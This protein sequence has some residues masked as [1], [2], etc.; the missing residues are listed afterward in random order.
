MN[1]NKNQARIV[2]V[3]LFFLCTLLGTADLMAEETIRIG[4]IYS[5]SGEAKNISD[6][7]L[8][9]TRFAVREINKNGGVLGRQLELIEVDNESSGIGS[10]NA[11]QFLVRQKVVAVVGPSWSSH[12]LSVAPVLQ[13]AAIPM[14]SPTATNPRVT[15]VGNYIFRICFID[16]FQGEMLAKFAYTDKGLKRAVLL[17]NSGHVYSTDLA[18]VIEKSYEQLGGKVLRSIDYVEDVSNYREIL[19]SLKDIKYDMIFIPGYARDAAHIIKTAEELGIETVFIGGDGWS[20][21]M[22]KYGGSSLN[23]NF[24]LT[25]WNK[26][27]PDKLSQDF[28]KKISTLFRPSQINAGMALAYDTIYLLADAITR[29]NSI[30][31]AAIRDALANTRK[32]TGVTGNVQFDKDR[33]PIKPAVVLEFMNGDA[34]V[35]KTIS[36]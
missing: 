28:V 15:L 5:L 25:H 7:H 21:L 19:Q 20:H 1:V 11:A 22:Y 14:L 26:S 34:I 2:T 16:S 10:R 18:D 23:G 4:A 6:E 27:V 33:N 30:E 32:F 3:I 29:V 36:K 35:V 24:Y 8:I 9:A 31:P 17:V 13:K 12:A